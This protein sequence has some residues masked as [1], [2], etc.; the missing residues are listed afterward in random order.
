MEDL[1][2][3]APLMLRIGIG[4]IFLYIGLQMLFHP[5]NWTGDIPDWADTITEVEV[6]IFF[7]GLINF[8]IGDLIILGL[9]T[10]VL[11]IIG[12]L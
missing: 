6:L 3:H 10:R 8:I 9:F 12:S 11:A 7:V 2:K 1:R 5:T 4:L